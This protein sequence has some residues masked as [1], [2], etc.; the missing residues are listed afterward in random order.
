M[1]YSSRSASTKK[2]VTPEKNQAILKALLK[3]PG[4]KYCADCKTGQHPRWASWSLGIFICIRCSGIHRSL[5]THISKVRSVDLDTWNDDQLAPLIN[6]G[7]QR[8]NL[9]WEAKLPDN[10]VPEDGKIASFIRTKYDLKR[11]VASPNLPD[12]STLGAG[13]SL[14]APSTR[15]QASVATNTTSRTSNRTLAK[16]PA[17]TS[18]IPDL[19]GDDSPS[20]APAVTATNQGANIVQPLARHAQSA[21]PVQHTGK[22]KE[23]SGAAGGVKQD[24]LLFGLD[25]GASGGGISSNG[26]VNK[27]QST[28]AAS[29]PAPV[30]APAASSRPD[31]KKSILSLYSSSNNSAFSQRAPQTQVPSASSFDLS[32]ATS[33]LS[34][35]PST[36]GL[37]SSRQSSVTS[38]NNS[39][40]GLFDS[41]VSGDRSATNTP[42]SNASN[43]STQTIP[44]QSVRSSV[45]A[46]PASRVDMNNSSN[47]FSTPNATATTSNLATESST[48]DDEEWSFSSAPPASVST[49]KPIPA[50]EDLFVNV[51]K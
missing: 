50:E 6:W 27:E 25:F 49:V 2:K 34:L 16:P 12:P 11:W 10:Y 44:S 9:Y 26:G 33:S 45:A 36:P 5:G 32:S 1:S 19:L 31:L 41:L 15:Q 47:F 7:N 13:T 24:S 39:N 8:A 35:G 4:N 14:P 28:S 20:M 18:L 17:A 3:D 43:W 30:P 29:V 48:Q 46:T 37:T 51:W 40:F 21:A 22:S 23:V 42:S 38:P